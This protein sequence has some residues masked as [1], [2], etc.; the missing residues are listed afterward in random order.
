MNYINKT[1]T[2]F[3]CWLIVSFLLISCSPTTPAPV[4]KPSAMPPLNLQELAQNPHLNPENVSA[5]LE[6]RLKL[7]KEQATVLAERLINRVKSGERPKSLILSKSGGYKIQDGI[8]GCKCYVGQAGLTSQIPAVL[9]Y[10]SCP[11]A[12][13]TWTLYPTAEIEQSPLL[14]AIVSNASSSGIS[15]GPLVTSIPQ[16]THSIAFEPITPLPNDYDL[17][18]LEDCPLDTNYT[19]VEY[20]NAAINR[21]GP[22][23]LIYPEGGVPNLFESQTEHLV[24]N[25]NPPQ[26]YIC[27]NNY[28]DPIHVL[29]LGVTNPSPPY[30]PQALDM[31][32]FF[33]SMFGVENVCPNTDPTPTPTP[34]ASMEPSPEPSATPTPCPIGVTCLPCPEGEICP[35]VAGLNLSV[36]ESI[37]SPAND[38]DRLDITTFHVTS[39]SDEPWTLSVAGE[40]CSWSVTESSRDKSIEWDGTCNNGDLMED[41]GYLV[42]LAAG[43]LEKHAQIN[44]DNTPPTI[45]YEHSVRMDGR[46][47]VKTIV[48]DPLINGYASGLAEDA[49]QVNI[50]DTSVELV[51]AS[52]YE[53]IQNIIFDGFGVTSLSE[54]KFDPF[55]ILALGDENE[56]IAQ[57]KAFNIASAIVTHK[58]IPKTGN[59][60]LKWSALNLQGQPNRSPNFKIVDAYD[61]DTRD[62]D[63]TLVI[64]NNFYRDENTRHAERLVYS[65]SDRSIHAYVNINAVQKDIV[66]FINEDADIRSSVYADRLLKDELTDG[67]YHTCGRACF[68]IEDRKIK[69]IYELAPS[70][71]LKIPTVGT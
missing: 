21:S 4:I 43:S 17:V 60:Q 25:S 47:I 36:S 8:P 39:S 37:I 42:K 35:P 34:S 12:K 30:N 20:V 46:K 50:P 70:L 10:Y 7:Q 31:K 61:F 28:F 6:N 67:L 1:V 59:C 15:G 27:A 5:F 63:I 44:I 26:Y 57:D 18:F 71:K 24:P 55:G 33:E 16:T 48:T 52:A 38:D 22:Y 53:V 58:P 9:H 11:N 41:G 40:N 49:V 66:Q 45:D 3:G 32:E 69:K 14:A 19:S 29:Q 54:G 65:I 23:P 51:S 2:A 68:P 62:R 64:H 56:V 13:V